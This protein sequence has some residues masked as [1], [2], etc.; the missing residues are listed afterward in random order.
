MCGL[1]NA[2]LTGGM[3]L[4]V[5][6]FCFLILLLRTEP[7]LPEFEQPSC[8]SEP[9]AKSDQR[10]VLE[11]PRLPG[12]SIY[13]PGSLQLCAVLSLVVQ[14]CPTLCG[15]MDCSLW[16]SPKKNTGVGSP[17]PEELPDPGIE[18]GAPALQVDS[19]PAELPGKPNE[20]YGDK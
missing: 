14:T 9:S 18:L 7:W 6:L 2:A 1:W 17:S 11:G 8:G 5:Y 19:L 4:T 12:S 20:C 10:K 13:L 15:P 3:S 16:N